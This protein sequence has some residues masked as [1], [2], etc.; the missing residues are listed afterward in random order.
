MPLQSLRRVNRLWLANCPGSLLDRGER[1]IQSRLRGEAGF[2]SDCILNARFA[3]TTL[4]CCVHLKKPVGSSRILVGSLNMGGRGL[5]DSLIF[6]TWCKTIW[7][8]YIEE[9]RIEPFL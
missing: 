4:L 1:K 8:F 5:Y 3:L 9:E 7:V 6:K 2:A